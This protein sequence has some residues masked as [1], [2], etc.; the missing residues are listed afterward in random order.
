MALPLGRPRRFA[1]GL[2]GGVAGGGAMR[3]MRGGRAILAQRNTAARVGETSGRT[4]QSVARWR[5]RSCCTRSRDSIFHFEGNAGGQ[6][7]I[8]EALLPLAASLAF[9]RKMLC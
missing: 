5:M 9:T 1:A 2:G 8:V 3:L 4:N 7:Q 6:R